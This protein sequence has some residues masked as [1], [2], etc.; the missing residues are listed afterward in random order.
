MTR[1][2]TWWQ[3]IALVIIIAGVLLTAWTAQQQDQQLRKDLLIKARI[4]VESID[5]AMVETLNGSPSDIASPDYQHLKVQMARIRA[6]D[7]SIRFA[8]LL[9]QRPEGVFFYVDSE[10]ADSVDNSPPGQVYTEVTDRIVKV[11]SNNQDMTEGPSPDR[12]GTWVTSVVPVTDQETGQL[13]ALFAMDV[14]ARY[15][16][17]TIAKELATVIAVTLLMLVLVVTFGLTQRRNRREQRN[18]AASEDKFSRTFH[19]NPALMAVSSIEDG[20]FIDVNSS[21]LQALGYSR[22][23]VIG[24]TIPD[25]GLYSD[26]AQW[27]FIQRQLKETG[28]IRRC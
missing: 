2:I 7:P 12:W 27:E 28:Q 17:Y 5:P 23:E 8:Y 11:F 18:L 6:A 26:P 1:N 14:D 10:P 13:V 3:V 24:R 25:L 20:R 21:F 15:W 19:T 9:G 22:E 4:A 16:T